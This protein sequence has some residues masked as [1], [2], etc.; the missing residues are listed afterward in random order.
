M[1]HV[2]EVLLVLLQ[3]LPSPLLTLVLF[4]F[5]MLFLLF[6]DLILLFGSL[7]VLGFAVGS[8]F[9]ASEHGFHEHFLFF[10]GLQPNELVN[11]VRRQDLA[12]LTRDNQVSV[13]VV[14]D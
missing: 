14:T 3:S 7:L 4:C 9:G 11:G 5:Q 12:M 2:R 13:R 8:I 10:G 1:K 6:G